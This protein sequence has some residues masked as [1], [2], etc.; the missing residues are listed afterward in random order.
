MSF[1]SF[2]SLVVAGAFLFYRGVRIEAQDLPPRTRRAQR[3]SEQ[4]K[5][6]DFNRFLGVPLCPWCPSW[7]PVLF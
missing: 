4:G 1:M 5:H 7:W 3:Q 6:F 2:V